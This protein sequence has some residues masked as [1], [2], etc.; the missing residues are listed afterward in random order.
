MGSGS[1]AGFFLDNVFIP[2]DHPFNPFGIDLGPD[3]VTGVNNLNQLARRPVEA[4]PRMFDQKVD[5]WMLSGA[6]NGDLQLGERTHYWDVSLNWGRNNASQTG[7]NIFNARKLALARSVTRAR[8]NR[9][10]CVQHFRRAARS[11][12]RCSIG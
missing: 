10:S 8:R 3:P 6:L 12:R 1:G 9:A 4:G 7:F 5:T 11:R 2:A